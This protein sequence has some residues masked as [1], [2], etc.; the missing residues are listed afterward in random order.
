MKPEVELGSLPADEE[1][2]FRAMHVIEWDFPE[3]FFLDRNRMSVMTVGSRKKILLQ[4]HC[5]FKTAVKT[6]SLLK[7]EARRIV[8]PELL[9]QPPLKR[10]E[11]IYDYLM[12]EVTYY[13]DEAAFPEQYSLVGPLVH[14]TAVCEGYAKA[15]R[16]LC[17]S[18]HVLCLVVRGKAA[19]VGEP[20]EGHAWNI[21]RLPEIGTR[22]LDVTWDSCLYHQGR[23][24]KR[25]YL[26]TDQEMEAEHEWDRHIVPPCI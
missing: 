26:R 24:E 5:D 6:E 2:L 19:P 3:L 17:K 8:T 21:V 16:Y 14:H 20:R 25:Y 1:T 10:L 18:A 9:Q 7:K 15:F 4:Y 12:K 11:V 22:Q 13:R 23:T